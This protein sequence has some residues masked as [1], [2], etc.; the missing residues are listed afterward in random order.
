MVIQTPGLLWVIAAFFLGLFNCFFGYRLFIVTVAIV[1]LALGASF[2]YLMGLSMGS[3]VVAF[4]AA[5]VLGLIGAWASVAAYYAFIFVAGAV[6]F[7]LLTA[8]VSGYFAE[9][10][11]VLIPILAGLAGGLLALW[12]QRIVI[13]AATAVQG[14]LASVLA[15]VSIVSSGGVGAYRDFLYRLLNGEL[16]RRGG[17]WFYLGMLLWLILFVCGLAT[18]FSRGKEMYRRRAPGTGKS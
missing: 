16:S 10:V 15:L 18:Q 17:I 12:L 8:F 1:G 14:A 3:T 11:P 9:H 4:V 5:V 13:I 6:G 2:G 7:A